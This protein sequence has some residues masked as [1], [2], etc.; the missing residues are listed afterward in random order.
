MFK[1]IRLSLPNNMTCLQCL[2]KSGV[3]MLNENKIYV[4][5]LPYSLP[6]VSHSIHH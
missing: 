1:F 3:F 4:L 5:L 6:G 2:R